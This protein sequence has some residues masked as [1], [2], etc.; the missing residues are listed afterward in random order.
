MQLGYA[1]S[2]NSRH[3]SRGFRLAIAFAMLSLAGMAL[4]IIEKRQMATLSQRQLAAATLARSSHAVEMAPYAVLSILEYDDSIE[5]GREAPLLFL[6]AVREARSALDEAAKLASDKAAKIEV[7]KRRFE[8]V[9]EKANAA[10]AVG[11]TTPG[12]TR[13][14]ALSSTDLDQLASGALLAAE[15]DAKLQSLA[16][17][18]S[19]LGQTLARESVETTAWLQFEF[20]VAL[21]ILVAV[22]LA[23]LGRARLS[24]RRAATSEL[25]LRRDARRRL[26]S[27]EGIHPGE[28]RRHSP[29]AAGPL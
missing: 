29:P 10:L 27:M 19:G 20:D 28:G 8:G 26:R 13:G 24:G 4:H 18:L 21:L 7:L 14:A 22:G 11:N 15:P 16:G 17:D 23:A 12:L 5:A 9:V 25:M 6:D 2:K 3:R 1:S